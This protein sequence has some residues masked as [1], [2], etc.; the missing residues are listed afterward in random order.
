MIEMENG[1]PRIMLDDIKIIVP[2]LETLFKE[3][4]AKVYAITSKLERQISKLER[5]MNGAVKQ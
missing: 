2:L 1:K 5:R 4:F 3:E